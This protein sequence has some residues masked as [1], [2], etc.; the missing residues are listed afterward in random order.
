MRDALAHYETQK[1]PNACVYVKMV[2]VC[3][4]LRKRAVN[5]IVLR[6][7]YCNFINQTSVKKTTR[8]I[9]HSVQVHCVKSRYE[10]RWRRVYLQVFFSWEIRFLCLVLS[11]NVGRACSIASTWDRD[12]KWND[13]ICNITVTKVA[14]LCRICSGCFS[15]KKV[16]VIKRWQNHRWL[17]VF[18]MLYGKC[19]LFKMFWWPQH[20]RPQR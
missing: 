13:A 4:F 20:H 15:V 1:F 19:L 5:D 17:R 7:H 14:S 11:L 9:L 3:V 12:Q 16:T 8:N 10:F 2:W 18:H 6:F